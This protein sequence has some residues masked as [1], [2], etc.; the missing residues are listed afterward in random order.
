MRGR[1]ARSKSGQKE[2]FRRLAASMGRPTSLANTKSLSSHARRA[3]AALGH[4]RPNHLR[5]S[6]VR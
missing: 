5:P 2:R 3:P 6:A 4:L 1:P